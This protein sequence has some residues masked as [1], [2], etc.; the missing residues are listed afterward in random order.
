MKSV[1]NEQVSKIIF[2]LHIMKKYFN[3]LISSGIILIL[4]SACAS[5]KHNAS[6]PLVN[7]LSFSQVQ[8]SLRHH[9]KKVLVDVYATWCGP[10]KKMD[11]KTFENPDVVK[12]INEN[13]YAIKFNAETMDTIFFKSKVFVNSLNKNKT[14]NLTYE[15]ASIDGR[16]AF[17]TTVLLDQKLDRIKTIGAFLYPA[18]MLELLHQINV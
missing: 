1:D 6:Q 5:S 2:Y 18:D 15:L 3:F 13:F 16:I 7:W 4:F 8:D 11:K 12:Y 14:H 17:P 9:P 10:C